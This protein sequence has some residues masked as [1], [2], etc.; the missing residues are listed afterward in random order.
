MLC[1]DEDCFWTGIVFSNSSALILI[2]IVC[3]S[4]TRICDGVYASEW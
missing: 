2:H 1:E 4:F 3:L